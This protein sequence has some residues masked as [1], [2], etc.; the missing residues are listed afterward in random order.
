LCVFF[1]ETTTFAKLF[2]YKIE[3]LIIIPL[4]IT[5]QT[6][7]IVLYQRENLSFAKENFIPFVWNNRGYFESVFDKIKL[8]LVI[9]ILSFV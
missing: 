1:L 3:K 8:Y 9:F 2:L 4:I 7:K 6:G 5:N